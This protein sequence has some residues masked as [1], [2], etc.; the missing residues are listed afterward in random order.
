M[1][2]TTTPETCDALADRFEAE[3]YE[4]GKPPHVSTAAVAI[5]REAA[6]G[7]R[8]DGCGQPGL[9]FMP[10][11]PRDRRTRGYRGLAWCGRCDAAFEM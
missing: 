3:G 11:R 1:T 5:D 6:A 9:E 2:T 10:Y 8:C 7:A 4:I